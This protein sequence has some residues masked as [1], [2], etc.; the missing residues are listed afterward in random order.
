MLVELNSN[1]LDEEEVSRTVDWYV[2]NK[3]LWED[4]HR[5]RDDGFGVS[6]PVRQ[7][8]TN[9]PTTAVQP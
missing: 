6:P 3:T 5:S 9:I 4:I 7:L 2:T 1:P 8:Q